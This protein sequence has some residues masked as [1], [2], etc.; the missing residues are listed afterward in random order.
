MKA[1]SNTCPSPQDWDAYLLSGSEDSDDSQKRHLATCQF[2]QMTV[3]W[4]M[5]LLGVV[6]EAMEKIDR[7]I[8][9]GFA[10]CDDLDTTAKGRLA[11]QSR[12]QTE[13]EITSMSLVSADQRVLL[14]VIKE[15]STQDFWLYVIADEAE[16]YQRVAVRPFGDDRE[17][18]TDESGKVFLGPVEIES[19]SLTKAEIRIPRAVFV[20]EPFR[21]Y[22]SS[23]DVVLRADTGD[24]I[25][26]GLRRIGSDQE[27]EI[28][29]V[30]LS[31]SSTS[32][33]FRLAVQEEG[34][35]RLR[36]L[37]VEPRP[38]KLDGFSSP[39][40]IRIYLIE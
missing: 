33:P 6:A 14:K 38:V 2:C 5:E 10:L 27:I 9:M 13:G 3:K 36:W 20:L 8:V 29:L 32:G 31:R 16:L 17:Y 37:A 12:V 11:A 26:V 24:E 7:S 25:R 40:V 30:K 18:I 23:G 39:Q 15:G 4:R 35:G 28:E 21:G 1:N 34:T 22:E 19:K